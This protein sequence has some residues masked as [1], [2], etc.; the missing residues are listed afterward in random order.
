M[1]QINA[2]YLK[3]N[4]D[5]LKLSAV[6]FSNADSLYELLNDD[7]FTPE[8][9]ALLLNE[10]L[11]LCSSEEDED[12]TLVIIDLVRLLLVLDKSFKYFAIIHMNTDKINYNELDNHDKLPASDAT[13]DC[14]RRELLEEFAGLDMSSFPPLSSSSSSCNITC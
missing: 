1:I 13:S 5:Y 9:L 7:C 8:F 14:L 6:T 3:I 2:H 10:T 11:C 12:S 4:H